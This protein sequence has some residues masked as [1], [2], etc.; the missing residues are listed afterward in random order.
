MIGAALALAAA[1]L[2][3]PSSARQRARA[4]MM[5]RRRRQRLTVLPFAVTACAALSL[6]MPWTALSGLGL[7]IATFVVRRRLG[8]RRRAAIAEASAL[9]SALDVL[10]GELRVG[11]HPVAAI[12]V[13]AQESDGCV[14]HSLR[15]VASRAFLGADVAA[16]LRAEAQRSTSPG[17]WERLAVCWQL[18]HTHGLAIATLMQAAQRDIVERRR[19]HQ[20]VEAGMA[21][22]RAT[23]AILAGLPLL[24]VL[25][26][27]SIGADPLS[28]LFSQGAGGWFL[29]VGSGLT[30][31]G[32]LWSDR[33]TAKVLT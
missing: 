14:A 4:L 33:I 21:G 15:S 11:A 25:L 2:L 24:G 1:V 7:L 28:F 29:V 30:C 6:L 3:V 9:Q 22:A 5:L 27:Q 16:G 10:V 23:A 13:A 17:H 20:G 18:A 32:L 12:G 19:F 8:L 26:G 31:C